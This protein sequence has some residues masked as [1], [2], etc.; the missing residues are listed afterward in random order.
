MAVPAQKSKENLS[1]AAAKMIEALA[2]AAAR[3]DYR[4]VKGRAPE[5]PWEE[6]PEREA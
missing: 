3:R 5:R 1:P 4:G 2:R 6:I